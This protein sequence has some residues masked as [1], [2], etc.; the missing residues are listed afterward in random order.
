MTDAI[1]IICTFPE[2]NG[3]A[4]CADALVAERLAACVQVQGPIRSTFRWQG[5]VDHATEWYCQVKTS[6]ERYPAVEQRI[7]ALHPYETPE[8]IALPVIAGNPAYLRWV[9]ESVAE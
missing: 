6:R 7:R 4:C 1:V 3:A 5:A 2:E 8:I 9:G